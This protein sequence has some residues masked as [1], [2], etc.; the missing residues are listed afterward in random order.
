MSVEVLPYQARS[1]VF[2]SVYTRVAGSGCDH[3]IF[4]VLLLPGS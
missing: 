4:D 3:N 2:E 1:E